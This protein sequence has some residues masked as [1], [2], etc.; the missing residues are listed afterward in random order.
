MPR[1]AHRPLMIDQVVEV[2]TTDGVETPVTVADMV[3]ETMAK[4]NYLEVACALA[5]VRKTTVLDWL[6]KGR[7]A[8]IRSIQGEEIPS[9]LRV[10]AEFSNRV[11]EAKATAEA[12]GVDLLRE[13]AYGGRTVTHTTTKLDKDGNVVERTVKDETLLPNAAA[14]MWRQERR[15]QK[16]WGRR[17][18]VAGP[19]GGSIP[20]E[21]RV[22][23]LLEAA[24]SFQE[25]SEEP[26]VG[27]EAGTP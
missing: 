16:R 20:V 4:G 11:A 22:Q 26:D 1:A 10:F 17:V 23:N 14:V 15:F 7:N 9:D 6:H 3:V 19:E 8:V 12:E 27:G 18:E 13:L 24:Q 5:G 25:R 21:V 2:R